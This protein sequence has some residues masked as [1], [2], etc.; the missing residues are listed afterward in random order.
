M[1]I[2]ERVWADHLTHKFW[3]RPRHG[4]IEAPHPIYASAALHAFR[5][6]FGRGGVGHQGVTGTFVQPECLPTAA[7]YGDDWPL[8]CRDLEA[9]RD[10]F[11]AAVRMKDEIVDKPPR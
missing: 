4:T 11:G 6:E 9:Q 2:M 5:C 8:I 3:F 7:W 10:F 1:S